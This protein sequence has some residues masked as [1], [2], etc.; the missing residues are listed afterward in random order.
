MTMLTP[1]C[2]RV[3]TIARK[4][5]P[6]R[7]TRVAP[8]PHVRLEFPG[9]CTPIDQRTLPTIEGVGLEADELSRVN[10]ARNR[11]MSVYRVDCSPSDLDLAESVGRAAAKDELRRTLRDRPHAKPLVVKAKRDARDEAFW[12][13]MSREFEVTPV[14]VH[15]GQRQ[16]RWDAECQ[17]ENWAERNSGL[18][19]HQP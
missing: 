11:A 16:A 12:A 19:G 6:I 18:V 17:S 14:R 9:L 1:V 8:R 15:I 3:I 7:E 5:V 13:A 2:P 4:V 10:R